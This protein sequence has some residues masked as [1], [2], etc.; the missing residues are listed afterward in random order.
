MVNTI[1]LQREFIR[2]DK[3]TIDIKKW[4]VKLKQIKKWE[5]IQNC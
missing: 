4:E 3:F 2:K 5:S 1:K